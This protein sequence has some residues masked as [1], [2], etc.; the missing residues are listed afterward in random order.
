MGSRETAGGLLCTGE[1]VVL[2]MRLVDKDQLTDVFCAFVRSLDLTLVS[3][4][5]PSKILEAGVAWLLQILGGDETG[6]EGSQ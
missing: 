5:E 1:G 2:V 4:G 3:Y 6:G